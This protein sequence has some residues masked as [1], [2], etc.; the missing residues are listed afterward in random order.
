[1]EVINNLKIGFIAIFVTRTQSLTRNT[2]GILVLNR[3]TDSHFVLAVLSKHKIDFEIIS[4]SNLPSKQTQENY[5]ILHLVF[6][7]EYVLLL[8]LGRPP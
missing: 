3:D 1:M 7:I 6:Q 4:K 8:L 5:F 2:A